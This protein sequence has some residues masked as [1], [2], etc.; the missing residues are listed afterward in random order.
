LNNNGGGEGVFGSIGRGVGLATV[1]TGGV[2]LAAADPLPTVTVTAPSPLPSAAVDPAKAPYEVQS[3]TSDDIGR[4]GAPA[5]SGA[6]EQRLSSIGAVDDL[7]DA[8]QPNILYRGFS[9]SPVL[10][11]A[12]GLAVYQ[13]GVRINE[14]FGDT[15][16]WDLILPSAVSRI[17]VAGSDPLY[18]ANALGGAVVVTMKDG[19]TPAGM[20]LDLVGG[21]FGR[22]GLDLTSA[23]TIGRLG[24][25]IAVRELD[26]DGW[27]RR[28]S[29]KLRQAYGALSWRGDRLNLDFSLALADDAL[30][31]Q[32]AA[33]VQELAVSRKLVFTSPQSNTNRLAFGTLSGAWRASPRLSFQGEVHVRGLT[34]A[35]V[36]GDATSAVACSAAT[37]FAGSLCQPDGATPLH[38][39][40]GG[41]IPDLSAG[42]A[43]PIGQNDRLNIQ[44]LGWGGGGQA[45]STRPLFGRPND[46]A[47]GFSL[48]EARVDYASS[49]EIGVIDA[50]LAVQPSGYVVATPEGTLFTATPVGLRSDTT[51]V[52]AFFSNSVEL[53]RRLTLTA[54]ARYNHL[55][56][57]LSDQRGTALSGATAYERL[58]PALGV[59]YRIGAGSTAYLGYA[60]GSRA[61]TPSEIECSSPQA[62]CLSPS[63]LSADPPVLKQVTSRTVEAGLRGE[64]AL[65]G[66]RATYHAGLYR[67]ELHDDIFAVATSLS[68]GYFQNIRGTLRQGASLGVDYKGRRISAQLSLDHVEARFATAVT[69]PSPANPL[70]DAK[71]DIQVRK[72]DRLPG[73]PRWRL[74][75]G[76]DYV[77]SESLQFGGDLRWVSSQYYRG[78]E[79]N[80]LAPLPGYAVADLH[81]SYQIRPGTLASL[82][83][84]NLFNRRYATFGVLGDPTGVGAPG[85]PSAG[86]GVADPRFQSPATP[87]AAYIGIQLRR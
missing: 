51:L 13:N 43:V 71:G 80:L 11:A 16:N 50:T 45:T 72:G 81:A 75:L 55:R 42:G 86:P 33:P 36:N 77:A 62:P 76:A 63:S 5:V 54:S 85:V 38:T 59:L 47:M 17:D 30:H 3:L 44:S 70:S 9:A 53:S 67:T 82:R 6:L 18:G 7:D 69:L 29:D 78:D 46:L 21:G 64:R 74:K 22:R 24:G 14:A 27:R 60:E 48:D 61:P 58:N 34:Q 65:L 31:G 40:G 84:E 49:A 83:V 23:G 1:L 12:E 52:G 57:T 8:F 25:F 26:Q 20:Q 73:V 32:G 28:S 2:A 10:G 68:A 4:S 15:V 41:A 39:T 56:I 35:I 37:P 19:F 79:A 87:V 66:G